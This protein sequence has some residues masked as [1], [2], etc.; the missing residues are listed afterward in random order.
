MNKSG[1]RASNNRRRSQSGMA[2]PQWLR[3]GIGQQKTPNS[4][5]NP[6]ETPSRPH[7]SPFET[8]R[9][10]LANNTPATGWQRA[11]RWLA[12]RPPEA[13]FQGRRPRGTRTRAF[14]A[15]R[16]SWRIL[17]CEES[18]RMPLSGA[19][20]FSVDAIRQRFRLARMT[21]TSGPICCPGAASKRRVHIN[22][23]RLSGLLVLALLLGI[24][25]ARA[26][27][28]DDE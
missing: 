26:D 4:L 24:L 27:G 7:R 2:T 16:P 12:S 13:R 17:R 11:C 5:R 19:T 8:T 1:A 20:P 10:Q 14:S 15:R 25:P 6:I 9:G 28:P 3:G 22:L 21:E 23:Q 18:G